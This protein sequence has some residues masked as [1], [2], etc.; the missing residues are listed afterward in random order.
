[1]FYRIIIFIKNIFRKKSRVIQIL[2]NN[3]REVIFESNQYQDISLL[4]EKYKN[5]FSK[6]YPIFLSPSKTSIPKEPRFISEEKQGKTEMY[7]H[8]HLLKFYNEKNIYIKVALENFAPDFI[9]FDKERNIIIDIEIDEPYTKINEVNFPIHFSGADDERDKYFISHGWFVIRFTEKQVCT[10]PESCCKVLA[11]RISEIA[12]DKKPL[13]GFSSVSDLKE[14]KQF[15]INEAIESAANNYRN[16]YQCETNSRFEIKELQKNNSI[17][18]TD[19]NSLIGKRLYQNVLEVVEV[20]E[21]NS[22]SVEICVC[23][24]SSITGIFL[25]IYGKDKTATNIINIGRVARRKVCFGHLAFNS[26]KGDYL[27]GRILNNVPV[28]NY[29]IESYSGDTRTVVLFYG[30]TLKG[31]LDNTAI[32]GFDYDSWLLSQLPPNVPINL[33]PC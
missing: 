33:Q 26:S 32:E 2:S 14:E 27:K 24:T 8:Q 1:M 13:I 22:K 31:F 6:T 30:E 3:G 20:T 17:K 16:S 7:F 5:A 28:K 11:K 21:I 19:D 4:K 23:Q 18:I 9:Y 12:K 15:T 29:T 25:N 10:A